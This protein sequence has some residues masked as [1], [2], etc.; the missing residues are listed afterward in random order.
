MN[1]EFNSRRLRR[2]V[3]RELRRRCTRSSTRTRS[4]SRTTPRTYDAA[5]IILGAIEQGRRP[6]ATRSATL[7]PA[8]RRFAGVTGTL[9]FND[10]REREAKD[11]VYLMVKGRQVD[12]HRTADVLRPLETAGGQPLAGPSVARGPAV[13]RRLV[14]DEPLRRAGSATTSG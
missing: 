13:P 11:Q 12:L 9:L 1:T 4:P 2:A 10:Q 5:R 7:S 8:P 14:P 3:V 6:T